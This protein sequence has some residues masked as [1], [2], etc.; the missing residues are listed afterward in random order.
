M[1]GFEIPVAVLKGTLWP[2]PWFTLRFRRVRAAYC[3]GGGVVEGPYLGD[4]SCCLNCDVSSLSPSF[5][6]QRN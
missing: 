2:L 1:L 5:T 6:L 4:F 3:L